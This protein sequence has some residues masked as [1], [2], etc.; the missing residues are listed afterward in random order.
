MGALTALEQVYEAVEGYE[1]D[2]LPLSVA[3]DAAAAVRSSLE[4]TGLLLLGECHG[5]AE[6]P[7]LVRALLERFD[8]LGL[9]LEWEADMRPALDAYLSDDDLSALA[10]HPLFWCGDGRL[11]AGHLALLRELA[12]KEAF[13]L[14]LFSGPSLPGWSA[15]DSAMAARLLPQLRTS[16]LV[17]AGRLHADLEPNAHGV[18]LG[19]HLAKERPGLRSVRIRYLGGGYFNLGERAFEGP[20]SERPTAHLSVA[21]DTGQLTLE[22]TGA[23]PAAVPYRPPLGPRR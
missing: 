21:D 1:P 18:P 20:T 9:A 7:L 10:E 3:P 17:V 19:A 23:T 12:R 8:L 5:V 16:T 15:R 22:L 11:A 6:N 13:E 2:S 14:A 4:S